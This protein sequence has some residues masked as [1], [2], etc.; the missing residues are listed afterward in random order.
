MICKLKLYKTVT[1]TSI[2]EIF[3]EYGPKKLKF[4]LGHKLSYN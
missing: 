3:S 1:I 4:E 2:I